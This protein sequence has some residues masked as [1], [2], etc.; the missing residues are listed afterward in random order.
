M[1]FLYKIIAKV[2][3]VNFDTECKMLG[4]TLEKFFEDNFFY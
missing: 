2:V 1:A 4:S 3:N